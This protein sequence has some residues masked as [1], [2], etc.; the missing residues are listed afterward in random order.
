MTLASAYT[1]SSEDVQMG[2]EDVQVNSDTCILLDA[3][4]SK[5]TDSTAILAGCPPP[6]LSPNI[7]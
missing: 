3:N 5:P 4:I 6:L 7:E 2:L 1:A